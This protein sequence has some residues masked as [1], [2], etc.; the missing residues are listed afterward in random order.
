V[1][2]REATSKA[3][4]AVALLHK[5]AAT[6]YRSTDAYRNEDALDPFRGRD[7]ALCRIRRD[8]KILDANHH[9][10]LL[11]RCPAPNHVMSTP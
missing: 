3:E 1:S 6:G 2:A 10:L 7:A 5:A 9:P 4:T 8:F 11:L